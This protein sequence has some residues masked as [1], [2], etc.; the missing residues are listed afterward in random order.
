MNTNTDIDMNTDTDTDL[1]TEMDTNT[2]GDRDRSSLFHRLH[3]I[4][5]EYKALFL[6]VHSLFFLDNYKL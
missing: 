4:E 2:E 5:G 3:I 1:D 6:V